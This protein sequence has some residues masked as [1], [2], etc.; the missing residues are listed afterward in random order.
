MI[1]N[2]NDMNGQH[3][4]VVT[5]HQR[6]PGKLLAAVLEYFIIEPQNEN[7]EAISDVWF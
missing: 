2:I 3:A 6:D 5:N 7:Y 4:A 1:T